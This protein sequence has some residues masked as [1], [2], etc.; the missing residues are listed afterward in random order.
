MKG[1]VPV[2]IR[3]LVLLVLLV[4]AAHSQAQNDPL[5]SWNDG[6]A[7]QAILTFVGATTDPASPNFVP[8]VDRIATFDQ[9]GTLWVE[10]PIY[11]Q[12]MYIL[13]RVHAVVAKKP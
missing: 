12:A 10:Q 7:K 2:R 8:P 11:T 3:S 6:K 9:D 13:D 5:P 1:R 4:T